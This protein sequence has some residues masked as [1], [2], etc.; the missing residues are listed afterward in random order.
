VFVIGSNGV[1]KF[2]DLSEGVTPRNNKE[3]KNTD[4]RHPHDRRALGLE[5]KNKQ[6][7]KYVNPKHRWV[8]LI[9][10]KERFVNIQLNVRAETQSSAKQASHPR[11]RS[12]LYTGIVSFFVAAS[13]GK[14][15]NH[16]SMST[17]F[18]SETRMI[19]SYRITHVVAGQTHCSSLKQSK[20]RIKHL[21]K[22][23]VASSQKLHY[24]QQVFKHW[25]TTS[26]PFI[27]KFRFI[28][29]IK[30]YSVHSSSSGSIKISTKVIPNM[31]YFTRFASS[32][33]G[34][35]FCLVNGSHVES[36]IWFLQIKLFAK[37]PET[38]LVM[39]KA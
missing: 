2:Y 22:D 14:Q 16:R 24:I 30:K 4:A 18:T 5:R 29:S 1:R 20:R 25:S 33:T 15:Y 38:K 6:A 13:T 36:S 3:A 31:Q 23:T 17:R 21:P 19:Y 35:W 39:C 27:G 9:I 10:R 12:Q 11:E 32:M 8:G 7:K 37:A 28:V 26:F 34:P